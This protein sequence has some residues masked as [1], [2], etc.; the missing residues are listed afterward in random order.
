MTAAAPGTPTPDRGSSGTAGESSNVR[1]LTP[2]RM[3]AWAAPLA[4]AAGLVFWLGQTRTRLETLPEYAMVVQG[5]D[6]VMRGPAEGSGK[7]TA[8]GADARF[9]LVARPATR[10]DG[11]LTAKAFAVR[12]GAPSPLE[13]SVDVSEE[14]AVRVVGTRDALR[15]PAR[16]ASSSA[17]RSSGRRLGAWSAPARRL[18]PSLPDGSCSA[19][20]W[21]DGSARRAAWYHAGEVGRGS[22]LLLAAPRRRDLPAAAQPARPPIPTTSPWRRGRHRGP[23][24]RGRAD[25]ARHRRDGVPDELDNCPTVANADQAD[26]IWIASATCDCDMS[27]QLVAAYKVF[28]SPL[29]ADPG[30]F[31]V[32]TGFTAANWTF[33]G[34]AYEQARAPARGTTDV[35][36]FDGESALDEVLLDV[37]AS[38]TEIVNAPPNFRQLLILFGA[39]ME[40]GQ[41]RSKACGIEVIDGVPE[42]TKVSVLEIS[43]PPDN[44]TTTEIRRAFRASVS[45]S[46]SDFFRLQMHLRQGTVSCSFSLGDGGGIAT[47]SAD[48]SDT[49]GRTGFMTRETKAKFKDL[50]ICRH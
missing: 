43:G 1:R 10:I 15:G 2:R 33:P 11:E 39:R 25:A 17:A 8:G 37:T 5:S 49:R 18:R 21:S 40:D 20:P 35:T 26:P 19:S 6:Q 41:L 50:R 3:I 22:L 46:G 44:L 14:G 9:E 13:A 45:G 36:F 32:P 12:D 29:T 47:V 42:P 34:D 23:R 31:T 48:V 24:G 38:S 27:E 28:E 30:T 4:L 16:S 7:L